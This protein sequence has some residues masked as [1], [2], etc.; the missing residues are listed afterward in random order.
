[1]PGVEII[2][3]TRSHSNVGVIILAAGSSTRMSGIDK[4]FIPL[5]GQ[6]LISYSLNVFHDLPLVNSIVLCMS[7]RNVEQGRRLVESSGWSKV[8]RVTLGGDRRQDSVRIGLEHMDDVDW[9]VVHD[10][11][12]PF[13]SS[14]MISRG[15]EEAKQTGAAVAA[16]PVK[17]TIKVVSDDNIVVETPDRDR[18]WASQTPQIFRREL[19]ARAHESVSENVTDDAAMVERIGGRVRLFMGSY[20]NIKVTTTEDL[21]IAEA[22]LSGRNS[23]RAQ[24]AQ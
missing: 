19:L 6:P 23:T 10:G 16:V 9:V 20:E 21:A 11:A 3:K 18:L 5:H 15:I 13:T 2:E 8:T 17:D 24:S 4:M 14:D 12:R 1:M 22:I 7:R